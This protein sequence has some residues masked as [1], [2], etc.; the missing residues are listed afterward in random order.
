[1]AM[2][3]G[4]VGL[5]DIQHQISNRQYPRG[6]HPGLLECWP[7]LSLKGE[8]ENWVFTSL[9]ITIEY[10]TS[11]IKYRISNIQH[12]TTNIKHRTSTFPVFI[13]EI[14]GQIGFKLFLEEA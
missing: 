4:D 9:K 13:R 14:C 3:D 5:S 11:N 12:P 6:P 7:T 1:M 10:P 8:G 2:G